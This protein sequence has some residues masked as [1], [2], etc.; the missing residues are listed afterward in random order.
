MIIKFVD[1]SE[2]DENGYRLLEFEVN[3]S[4]REVKILDRNLE[5]KADHRIKADKSNPGHLGSTIP[6]TVG[7]VLVKEGDPV[8]V[9]MPLLTV[10]AMK[11]ETSVEARFSGV[12][13]HVYVTNGEPIQSGDLLIEVKE[14]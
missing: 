4:M 5:V 6:G 1:M 13:E 8:T 3:G 10:E 9:N 14:K 2:P 7:K 11:M 12:V